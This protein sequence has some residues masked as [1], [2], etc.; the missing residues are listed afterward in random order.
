MAQLMPLP[1]IRVVLDKGTLN[2]C[3]CVCLAVMALNGQYNMQ[4]CW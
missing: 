3:E 4:M 2:S 1:L